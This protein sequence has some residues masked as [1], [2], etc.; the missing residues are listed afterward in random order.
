MIKEKVE[1]IYE[2]IVEE[3]I[4]TYRQL[5]EKT[6]ITD[7]T[8]VFWKKA[9]KLYEKLDSDEKEV[10][11]DIIEQII[12]DTTSSIFGIFDGSSSVAG[13]GTLET[14]IKIRQFRYQTKFTR[15]FPRNCS[16]KKNGEGKS[17]NYFKS[18]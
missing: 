7:K 11:F 6:K 1:I 5:Y 14:D 18:L 8:I 2:S 3:G 9:I 17:S 4:E 12:I 10:F 13:G 15:L 16:G